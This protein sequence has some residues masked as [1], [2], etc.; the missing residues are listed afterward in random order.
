MTFKRIDID[1]DNAVRLY[2]AGESAAQIAKK[3]GVSY[4]TVLRRMRETGV[5]LRPR[6][7]QNSINNASRFDLSAAVERYV[8]GETMQALAREF[9]ITRRR[10][11]M[12]IRAAGHQPRTM[13]QAIGLR[14]TR[15]RVS[16]RRSIVAKAHIAKRGRNAS[17]KSLERRARTMEATL[18][19]ASRADLMLGIWLAQ[20]GIIFTPQKAVGRYNV[21]LAIE[22][23]RVAVEVNGSWHYFADRISSEVKRREYLINHGW[24]L[25]EVVLTSQCEKV[26]KYLRP[27]CADKVVALVK[28]LRA[29]EAAWGQHCMIGGDGESL[30]RLQCNPND[31]AAVPGA[32][33]I[34]DA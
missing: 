17:E 30:S 33:G 8:A 15:M 3:M 13:L 32:V 31:G 7:A 10:M 27:A 22:E 12:A 11:E 6:G 23:L 16:E 19:L 2:Q 26:W 25:I 14:Y 18:Q 24:R 20:R 28:M 5:E 9:G 4:L 34:L 21:D 1:T 29:D